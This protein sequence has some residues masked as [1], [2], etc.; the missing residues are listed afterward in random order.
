MRK[1]YLMAI[2]AGLFALS[3]VADP[4]DVP[5]MTTG[6][7]MSYLF[8]GGG[9]DTL[10]MIGT[11]GVLALDSG[12]TTTA[13]I[14]NATYTTVSTWGTGVRTLNLSYDLTLDGVTHTI[15]Q[16]ATWTIT[17]GPDT[18]AADAGAPVTFDT[19]MGS[20]NVTADPFTIDNGA[21]VGTIPLSI[22]ADF[23]PIP[24]TTVPEPGSILVTAGMLAGLGLLRRRITRSC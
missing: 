18:F 7:T 22:Q 24:G 1:T 8:M 10:D 5:Y 21:A 20:W 15:S 14:L 23:L 9:G 19:A 17:L 16:P 12:A 4:I 2:A 13:N 11:S 3:A 6:T